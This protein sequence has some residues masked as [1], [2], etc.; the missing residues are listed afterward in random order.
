MKFSPCFLKK[1]YPEFIVLASCEC[2]LV[3]L[4]DRKPVVHHYWSLCAVDVEVDT[5]TTSAVNLF[6]IETLFNSFRNLCQRTEDSKE[7]TVAQLSL[8]DVIGFNAT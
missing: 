8:F 1:T 6:G 5:V 4:I 2:N 3:I 7:V